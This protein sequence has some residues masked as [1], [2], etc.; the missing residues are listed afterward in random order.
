[1]LAVG[2]AVDVMRAG[3]GHQFFSDVVDG[4]GVLVVCGVL[5]AL[6]GDFDESGGTVLP[7]NVFCDPYSVTTL[8]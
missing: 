4:D 5:V 2:V 7:P 6:I 8:G 3:A 1:M